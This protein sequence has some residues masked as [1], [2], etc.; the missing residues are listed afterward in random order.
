MLQL[1]AGVTLPL[2]VFMTAGGSK[3]FGVR[4]RE[5]IP[6]GTFVTAYVGQLVTDAMAEARRGD[7][8]YLFNLDFFAHIYEVSV[9]GRGREHCMFALVSCL[10]WVSACFTDVGSGWGRGT[11]ACSTWN[12][13]RTFTR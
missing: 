12:S 11:R 5:P 1:T 3:G 2:E 9:L 7:D 13:L 8:Q 4:C 6:A 10:V